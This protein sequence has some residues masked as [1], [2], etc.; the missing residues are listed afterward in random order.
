VELSSEWSSKEG[1]AECFGSDIRPS[2]KKEMLN[3][4]R[5]FANLLIASF[6]I[7]GYFVVSLVQAIWYAAS[8]RPDKIADAFGYLGRGA[9]DA[10]SDI[11]K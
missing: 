6:R 8:G 7:F 1:S 4:F 11:F 3:P 5:F 2:S 9:V 10:I